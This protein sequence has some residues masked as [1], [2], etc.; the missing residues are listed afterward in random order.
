MEEPTKRS[1]NAEKRRN[2]ILKH[3]LKVF[4]KEGYH[5]TDVQVIADLAKVGKGTVYRHFGNKK[6]LFLATGSYCLEML[7]EFIRKEVGGQSDDPAQLIEQYGHHGV[8]KQI[9]VAFARFYQAKPQAV[10]LMIQER[11]EFRES[12]FPSH[13][14]H[15]A[16]SRAGLDE[17]IAGAVESGEF[18]KIEP[19]VVTDSFADLLFGAVV[20]GCLEG[21]RANLVKRVSDAMDIFLSGLV[22]NNHG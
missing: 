8:M 9:A 17:L 12:V 13:L 6:E 7:G 11:A 15:R 16:E 4:A 10:E 20:N 3:A 14:M 22:A 2:A 21:K 19:R 5:E 18:R 1:L